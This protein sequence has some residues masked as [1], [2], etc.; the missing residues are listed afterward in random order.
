MPACAGMTRAIPPAARAQ[1]VSHQQPPDSRRP[2]SRVVPSTPP[3]ETS[4]PVGGGVG[5]LDVPAGSDIEATGGGPALASANG[6]PVAR[7]NATP[8]KGCSSHAANARK[9]A[10]A[11]L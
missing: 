7:M 3:V 4:K 5:A 10:R 9:V 1:K 11:E 6:G 8:V 2:K